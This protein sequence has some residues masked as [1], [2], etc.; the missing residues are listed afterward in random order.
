MGLKKIM[1]LTPTKLAQ[2]LLVIEAGRWLGTEEK[3]GHNDGDL[4]KMFQMA[5]NKYPKREAWCADFVFFCTKAVTAQ[6]KKVIESTYDDYITSTYLA[7]SES[8]ISMWDSYQNHKHPVYRLPAAGLLAVWQRGNFS[9]QGHIGVVTGTFLKGGYRYFTTIE[10][11]TEGEG[12]EQGVFAK[13]RSCKDGV[14]KGLK[15]LGFIQA[16]RC[17]RKLPMGKHQKELNK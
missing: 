15:L 12:G 4:I 16:I 13:V 9:W 11:N 7:K 3:T 8:V 10:G 5:V 6:I 14:D 2:Q 1:Y 17:I